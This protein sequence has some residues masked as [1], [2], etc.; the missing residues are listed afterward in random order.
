[1][2]SLDGKVAFVTAAGSGIGRAAAIALGGAGASVVVNDLAADGLEETIELV[3]CAG[4][5]AASA[6]G[7]VRRR[8]DVASAIQVARTRFGGLDI[9]VANAAV[10]IY[11]AF[12]RMSEETREVVTQSGAV[13]LVETGYGLD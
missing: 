11:E 5:Q 7:D 10:S 8:A 3:E 4:A 2:G 9:A 6:V 1:M 13:R 12:D